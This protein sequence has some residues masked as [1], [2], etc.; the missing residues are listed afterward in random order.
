ME[1]NNRGA[2]EPYVIYEKLLL[3]GNGVKTVRDIG[4]AQAVMRVFKKLNH[5]RLYC[6][7]RLSLSVSVHRNRPS[8]SLIYS[9]SFLF[10]Q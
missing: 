4:L 3:K 6:G 2:L 10:A 5:D 8:P 1:Q 9:V 7:H